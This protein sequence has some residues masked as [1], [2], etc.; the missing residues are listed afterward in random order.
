[1]IALGEPVGA[2]SSVGT[3]ATASVEVS[4]AYVSAT[5]VLK[6]DGAVVKTWSSVMAGTTYSASF[7]ITVGET[8]NY[9]FTLSAEGCADVEKAGSITGRRIVDWFSVPL[10]NAAYASWTLATGADPYDPAAR[11]TLSG[12]KNAS[13]V[14]TDGSGARAIALATGGDGAVSYAP[15]F[16]SESGRTLELSGTATLFA[17]PA[18]PSA[19]EDVPLAGLTVGT[20]DGAPVI[21]GFG[22]AGWTALSGGAVTTN[23]PVAWKATLDFGAG[24]I[25]YSLGGVAFSPN[26]ALPV[27]AELATRVAF[28][29]SGAISAFRGVY[30]DLAGGSVTLCQ[31]A[32]RADGTGLEFRTVGTS[33]NFMI[34]L[35]DTVKDRWYVA[36]AADTLDTPEAD[37]VCVS[38]EQAK[39]DGDAV[40]LPCATVD[41]ATGEPIPSQF[42]KIFGASDAIPVGTAFGDLQSLT[43][44]H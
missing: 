15:A 38:C 4:L 3:N 20:V 6:V 8:K 29:G 1:M 10:T 26:T 18:T 19:P 9:V 42:F 2:C 7:P 21:F 13:T 32:I 14:G 30:A 17:H 24:T 41:A 25:A 28:K 33:E 31:A 37:W 22:A 39:A 44:D 23:A 11:W 35:R 40:D 36:F 12:A 34:G 43:P 5:L 27:G 16:P